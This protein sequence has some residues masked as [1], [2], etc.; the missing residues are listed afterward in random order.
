MT[1]QSIALCELV[2]KG[3]DTDLVREM[4]Q[5]VMDMDV[6]NL[7]AAAYGERTAERQ[8]K[9]AAAATGNASGRPAPAR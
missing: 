2:E 1:K 3:T 9:T 6:E 7:C 5:H 4:I 8:H